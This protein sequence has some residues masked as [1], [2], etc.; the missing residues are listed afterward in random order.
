MSAV[1]LVRIVALWVAVVSLTLGT[2]V[3]SAFAQAPA[4]NVLDTLKAA[5]NFTT[6]LRKAEDAGLTATLSGPGPVTVLAPTDEAFGK[7]P[8]ETLDAV[9]A[10]ANRLT[11]VVKNHIVEGQQIMAEQ[12]KTLQ[13]VKTA[14]GA[15]LAIKVEGDAAT[16]GSAKVVRSIQASNGKI[17]VLDAVLMPRE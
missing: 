2:P 11:M 6:F 17:H 12:I 5:G 1:K 8:K 3:L 15:D 9:A 16:I 14:A 13:A 4:Q 7:L 10:D